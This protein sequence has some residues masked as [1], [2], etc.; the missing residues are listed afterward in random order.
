MM[1]AREAAER[2][3]VNQSRVRALVASGILDARRVG[4]QW[5][6]DTDSVERQA[7]FTSAGATG[8]PMSRGVAWAASALA[9]GGQARW[10]SASDRTRL[11]GR[12]DGTTNVVVV[13]KWLRSRAETITRYRVGE[14][15]IVDLLRSDGVVATGVS[16][17]GAYGLGLSTG[18][19]AD[20]YVAD[21]LAERLERDFVL[22]RSSTGNL[23]L[24]IAPNDLHL[25]SAR[26]TGDGLFAPRLI[27]GVDL[28]DDRD[29][30]TTSAGQSMI[31]E[32]LADRRWRAVH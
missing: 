6:I 18:G 20:A 15:D 13:Q 7:A 25:R 30:R 8:R 28:A 29:P 22:I 16:A 3:N 32:V 9:D 27:A 23:T 31:R 17:A 4:S 24:R 19:S 10:I 1:T 26:T 2:L 12:L 21:D 11:R 14:R 5:L